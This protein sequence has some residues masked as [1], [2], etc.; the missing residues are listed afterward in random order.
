MCE[1]TDGNNCGNNI[2][3]IEHAKTGNM[4]Q[5]E[6]HRNAD[7][8]LNEFF[9]DA[10]NTSRKLDLSSC[11]LNELPSTFSTLIS[12]YPIAASRLTLLNLAHNNLN[13][14]PL[15]LKQLPNLTI[16][17]LLAN[18]FTLIPEVISKLCN[19]TML[20]FKQNFI[21]GHLQ[22]SKQL[23]TGLT[24]LI[25][26]SNRIKS[27]SDD[28]SYHCKHI[29]KLMLSNNELRTLPL[30]L[31]LHMKDLE[32]LRIANN[33]FTQF[34]KQI[35]QLS[36]LKWIA[37]SGNPI[38]NQ[39][40]STLPEDMFIS[41]VNDDYDILWNNKPLG[42]GTSG[43][44]YEAKHK[45][46]KQSVVVK[47]FKSL[48]GSDGRSIDEIDL[49]CSAKGIPNVVHAI[50]YSVNKHDDDM[51]L[52]MK[53]VGG[54]AWSLADGPS[55]DT[56]VRSVYKHGTVMSKDR[57]EEVIQCIT[58]GVEGLLEKGI[59]HGDVYA[60]NILIS[61]DG[62]HATLADFGAAWRIPNDLRKGVMA[63][64]RRALNV[65]IEEIRN[66]PHN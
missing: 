61:N 58:N 15:Y 3:I 27:I 10:S 22:A 20:S 46:T 9:T 6:T 32:L 53:R 30:D 49:S 65:F 4:C 54:D 41:D 57:K 50:A 16:L 1:C 60:H 31:H 18:K 64:E 59:C 24:W 43:I 2:T 21:H 37:M 52:V 51:Y 56:C 40:N 23:P 63:I 17:F 28:F 36:N 62:N 26:T 14:L 38:I 7:E 13:T 48:Q 5:C 33:S 44:A 66:L 29:R 55:F 42:S 39:M 47:K 34:P 8:I 12:K 11:R 25:L 45:K 35:L 19:L